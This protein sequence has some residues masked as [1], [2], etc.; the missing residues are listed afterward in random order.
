MPL[1]ETSLEPGSTIRLKV[2]ALSPQVILTPIDSAEKKTTES[3]V[4]S[5]AMSLSQ[6]RSYAAANGNVSDFYSYLF[7]VSATSSAAIPAN[8]MRLLQTLN[9]SIG[10]FRELTD[11]KKLKLALNNSGLL[12]EQKLALQVNHAGMQSLI[13]GSDIKAILLQ[14]FKSL[15]GRTGISHGEHSRSRTYQQCAQYAD[16]HDNGMPEDSVNELKWATEESL[17][18]II[19]K[20]KR[21]L[22]ESSADREY[23]MHTLPVIVGSEVLTIA[24]TLYRDR[25]E[26]TNK[27]HGNQMGAKFSMALPA[28]G[29]LQVEI[30]IEGSAAELKV[31]TDRPQ[32]RELLDRHFPKLRARLQEAGLTVGN[33]EHQLVNGGAEHV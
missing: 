12:L 9:K 28:A 32:T 1:S 8:S 25:V 21:S 30:N 4:Q 10:K 3:S 7:K 13:A 15:H 11:P 26:Y 20:Q 24:I 2:I 31:G 16:V 29:W 5:N 33:I 18:N 14:L 19:A 17:R 23:W 6:A 22:Y 27:H